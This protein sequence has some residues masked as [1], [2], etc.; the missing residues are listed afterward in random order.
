MALLC[1]LKAKMPIPSPQRIP[2]LDFFFPQDEILKVWKPFS[3]PAYFIQWCSIADA[4]S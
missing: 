2:N 1:D 4:Q 3:F